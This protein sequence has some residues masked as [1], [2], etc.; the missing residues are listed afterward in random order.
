MPGWMRCRGPRMKRDLKTH[1]AW[2]S[3]MILLTLA[4]AL[5]LLPWERLLA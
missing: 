5:I 1:L 3:A 4:L 2:A